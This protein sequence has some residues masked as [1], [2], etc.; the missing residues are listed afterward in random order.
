MRRVHV[1]ADVAKFRV[2]VGPEA[3]D[4]ERHVFQVG[5]VPDVVVVHQR[6]RQSAIVQPQF[7]YSYAG[8]APFPVDLPHG[9]PLP[10]DTLLLEPCQD[11]RYGIRPIGTDA[12][13]ALPPSAEADFHQPSYAAF[14]GVPAKQAGVVHHHKRL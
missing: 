6:D 11:R 1:I 5:V 14:R 7:R 2:P 9:A 13:T 8:C 3:A 12:D 4:L 10:S